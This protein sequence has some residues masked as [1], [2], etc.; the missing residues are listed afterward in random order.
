MGTR[1]TP[2]GARGT[3]PQL[4]ARSIHRSGCRVVVGYDPDVHTV[5]YFLVLLYPGP[6]RAALSSTMAAH[7]DHIDAMSARGIVLLGGDFATPV[8]GAEAAYLLHT[9]TAEEAA[10][11]ARR[12]PHVQAAVYRF[13][14]VPWE[15]VG[16][17]RNAIDPTLT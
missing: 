16:I 15:L 12:D 4:P 3:A 10:D 1:A 9:A 17:G 11:W 6:S 13:E 2:S 5:I 7:V 8:D 14:I